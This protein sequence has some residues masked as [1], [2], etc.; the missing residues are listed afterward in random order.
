MNDDDIAACD[1]FNHG[2]FVIHWCILRLL[3]NLV[4]SMVIDLRKLLDN[5]LMQLIFVNEMGKVYQVDL[6]GG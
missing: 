2:R 6:N 3:K 1:C 4:D 5:V